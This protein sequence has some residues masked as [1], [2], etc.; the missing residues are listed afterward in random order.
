MRRS[1]PSSSRS[2]STASTSVRPSPLLPS[3][4]YCTVQVTYSSVNLLYMCASRA[5]RGQGEG[6]LQA[7]R[8]ARGG[9]VRPRGEGAAPGLRGARPL[10]ST[11][12]LQYVTCSC[13]VRYTCTAHSTVHVDTY[14][15]VLY[16]NLVYYTVLYIVGCSTGASTDQI[17]WSKY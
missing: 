5:A 15:T 12:P 11:R 13:T 3:R 14:S 6:A 8:L 2:N 9:E 1:R 4:V 7:L 17:Q 10:S 16:N